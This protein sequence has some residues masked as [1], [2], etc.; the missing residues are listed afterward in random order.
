MGT[1]RV[2]TRACTNAVTLM[3]EDAVKPVPVAGPFRYPA[4]TSHRGK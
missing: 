3:D 2:R 4:D 1:K